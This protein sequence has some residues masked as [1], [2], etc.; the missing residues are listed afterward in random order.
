[1][2]TIM[3]WW[4]IRC[5][6]IGYQNFFQRNIS[7]MEDSENWVLENPCWKKCVGYAAKKIKS[8]FSILTDNVGSLSVIGVYAKFQLGFVLDKCSDSAINS[9]KLHCVRN[10]FSAFSGAFKVTHCVEYSMLSLF[11]WVPSAEHS[12]RN[13]ALKTFSQ[14]SGLVFAQ[15]LS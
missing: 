14:F 3:V 10:T 5:H 1:M 9:K 2:K 12:F 13:R 7:K 11:E 8:R 4:S 15:K 6:N